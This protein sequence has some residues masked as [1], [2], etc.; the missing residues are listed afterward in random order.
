M[1]GGNTYYDAEFPLMSKTISA[2]L[3]NATAAVATTAG[4]TK[5]F[6]TLCIYS[7]CESLIG[8]FQLLWR[9]HWFHAFVGKDS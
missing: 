2:S 5:E 9:L 8:L 3:V 6:I 7:S 4:T 1:D